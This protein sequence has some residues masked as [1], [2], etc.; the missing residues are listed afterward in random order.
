MKN[1]EWPSTGSGTANEE[2]KIKKSVNTMKEKEMQETGYPINIKKF[3]VSQQGLVNNIPF[4]IYLSFLAVMYIYNGHQ[5]EKTI[6]DIS[7]TSR[8]LKE[9]QYEFKMIRKDW[10]FQTQQSEIVKMIEPHGIKEILEAPIN[11]DNVH[12]ENIKSK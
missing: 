10:M 7:K 5:A 6:K 8:E 2:L 3:F 1:E 11:L 12:S 4:F 9:L